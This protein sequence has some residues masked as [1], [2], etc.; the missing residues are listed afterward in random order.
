MAVL[1]YTDHELWLDLICDQPEHPYKAPTWFEVGGM[2]LAAVA[3]TF[4]DVAL[5]LATH[6]RNPVHH[7]PPEVPALEGHELV[8][9]DVLD[10]VA[11]SER[12]GAFVRL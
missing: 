1:S 12:W 4:A 3:Y 8:F 2:E 6:A 7:H 11:F 9:E 5:W 10:G